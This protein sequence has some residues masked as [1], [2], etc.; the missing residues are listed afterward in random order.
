[1][2][3]LIHDFLPLVDKVGINDVLELRGNTF[4]ILERFEDSCIGNLMVQIAIVLHGPTI[5]VGGATSD[6]IA[7]FIEVRVVH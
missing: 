7:R 1:M 2:L 3:E 6:F 4:W 5:T